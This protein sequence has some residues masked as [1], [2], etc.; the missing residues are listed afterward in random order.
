[1][2]KLIP[3]V[4]WPQSPLAKRHVLKNKKE[5]KEIWFLIVLIMIMTFKGVLSSL[6]VFIT[7]LDVLLGFNSYHMYI[8]ASIQVNSNF[9]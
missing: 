9:L 1:M 8:N 7:P 4:V 2:L 6:Q 3:V 5:I